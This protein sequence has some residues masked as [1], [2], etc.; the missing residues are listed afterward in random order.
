MRTVT[1]QGDDVP[2]DGGTAC[3]L[4]ASAHAAL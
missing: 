4:S 2:Q 1:S 3:E